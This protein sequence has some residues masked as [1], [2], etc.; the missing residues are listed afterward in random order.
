MLT[1][2]EQIEYVRLLEEQDAIMARDDM[3]EYAS[4]VLGMEPAKHH[5]LLNAALEE[6]DAG[7]WDLLI[8]TMPPGS[9]KSSYGSVVFPAWY[10]G[11]HPNRCV[12]AASHTQELAE[13][14]GKRVRNIVGGAEHRKVFPEGGLSADSTAAGRWDTAKGGEYF[15]AG[16]GGSVTGRRADCVLSNTLVQSNRGIVEIQDLNQGDEV[17]SYAEHE[18]RTVYRRVVAVAKREATEYWRI[19]TAS[20]RLVEATGN[21]LFYVGGVWKAAEAVAVGDVFMSSLQ[22]LPPRTACGGEVKTF[23][24]PVALVERVRETVEVF[25]IQVEETAC[26]FAGGVLVHNCAII[27]DPVKSREDA[28]SETIREKQWA[29]WRDDMSTRLKPGAAVVLI[30]CMTGDTPVMLQDGSEKFL[31]DIRPGD[32]VAS[33]K[34]GKLVVATVRNWINNGL[35]PVFEIKMSSGKIVKANARHPFLVSDN[36]EPKWVRLRNLLPGQE[37]FRVNGESGK[38]RPVSMK[39]ATSLQ[40][41]EDIAQR[42]TTRFAGLKVLDHLRATVSLGVA[43][44]SS[45]ATV[46]R[47]KSMTGCLLRKMGNALS[48]VRF[49]GITSGRTGAGSCVSTTATKQERSGGCSATTA[50]WSL[51]TQ[52]QKRSP[53]QPLS[54]SDFTLDQIVEIS[55]AGVEEVFDIQVDDTEN[56]IANGLVSH[57]TRWHEADLAGRMIAD[58]KDS[59]QR[60]KVLSLPMEAQENDPLGRAPGDMLWP[61]WFTPQMLEQAKREPRTW[62]ALY[63]QEP[64]PIG[65]GEFKREWICHY[66][67]PPA[68][69]SKVILVDPASGKSKTRGDFTA[70]WV[71][72]PGQDGNFY[73][74]D[75]VRDRLNLTERSA[76]LFER[77]HKW[78]PA[79]VG[80]EQY[81]LQ[82]DIEFIRN[83]Q[84]R[85]QHRF[86]VVE[87]GGAIK[88]EDRIRRLIPLF[89]MG[90]IWFPRQ[91]VRNCSDGVSRDLIQDF[92]EQEYL[93][94]PVSAHDDAIDC[95]ARMCDEVISRSLKESPREATRRPQIRPFR[96]GDAAMG[97]LG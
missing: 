55:A 53:Q 66:I 77:V 37:I 30:M 61:E 62:S 19:R 71:L 38:T 80:Y 95:L 10:L 90:R 35:D 33:Y 47:L 65:G 83:E 75:A 43:Q 68:T 15:A 26:F 67:N 31:R 52:R 92:I 46:S 12:I 45:I 29:W 97:L 9:A 24:D 79:V 27:D 42:T 51:D 59:G 11:R 32:K 88:K 8:V 69:G 34:D 60:V 48:A 56:F 84:E 2:D 64:R 89:E 44:G 86:R 22:E 94:F 82:A 96:P 1:P 28:D 50:T 5:R 4:R 14:F 25:D 78:K 58:A 54:T 87:L 13:R 41:A 73:V 40:N 57:N 6:V 17:L 23:A 70:M 20:G 63:Q 74:L 93:A 36:G 72:G 3:N 7:L 85:Q 39:G 21:H 91:L 16:V 49:Q 81:G 76:K 18:H